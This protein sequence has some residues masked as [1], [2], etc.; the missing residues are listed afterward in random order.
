MSRKRCLAVLYS[1]ESLHDLESRF[2][3]PVI[4]RNTALELANIVF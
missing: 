1:P 3:N 2:F 4:S